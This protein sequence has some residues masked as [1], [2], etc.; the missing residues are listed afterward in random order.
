[1]P[2]K[3]ELD[4]ESATDLLIFLVTLVNLETEQEITEDLESVETILDDLIDIVSAQLKIEI[5]ID[6]FDEDE[7]QDDHHEIDPLIVH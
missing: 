7:Q 6:P 4:D 5:S 1:M 3:I 2:V